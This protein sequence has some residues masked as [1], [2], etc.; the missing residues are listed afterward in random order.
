MSDSRTEVAILV[1]DAH[2]KQVDDV[3][4][5][6]KAAGLNVKTVLREVGSITG[7]ITEDQMT[8]LRDVPGVGHVEVSRRVQLPPPDSPVQ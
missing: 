8:S 2:L 4:E 3:V 6:L 7:E 5:G 1:D